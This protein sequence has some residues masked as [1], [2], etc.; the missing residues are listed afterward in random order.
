MRAEKERVVARQFEEMQAG[1][2]RYESMN[3]ILNQIGPC[4]NMINQT[5]DREPCYI[6]MLNSH[7]TK[8][9]VPV[10]KMPQTEGQ[11]VGCSAPQFIQGIPI[12]KNKCNETEPP[13]F[14]SA[15]G[16]C[17]KT[18]T[19]FSEMIWQDPGDRKKQMSAVKSRRSKTQTK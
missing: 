12:W 18:M 17:G 4:G 1:P 13:V 15:Q 7:M 10:R 19:Q 16:C 5:P 3:Y 6:P 9:F 14:Q 2:D 8:I 11:A